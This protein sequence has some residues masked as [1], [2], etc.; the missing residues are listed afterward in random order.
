[1]CSKE[2]M[3]IR[4]HPRAQFSGDGR[5]FSLNLFIILSICCKT[6]TLNIESCNPLPHTDIT[7]STDCYRTQLKWTKTAKWENIFTYLLG[8]QNPLIICQSGTK[9]VPIY[10]W[11]SKLSQKWLMKVKMGWNMT[12]KTLCQIHSRNG[13]KLKLKA[14]QTLK[15]M[16]NQSMLGLFGT[17]LLACATP[18][19]PPPP[20]NATLSPSAEFWTCQ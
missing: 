17:I 12:T 19:P 6:L 5:N 13:I 16:Y 11:V 2:F 1:M 15:N 14:P 8:L 18:P 4:R 7:L 20:D 10:H 9:R 3:L